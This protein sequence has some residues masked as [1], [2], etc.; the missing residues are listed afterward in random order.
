MTFLCPHCHKPLD[1]AELR[2]M[3]N[4][5]IAGRKRPG[6]KGLVRNPKGRPKVT[7]DYCHGT[8]ML[9]STQCGWCNNGKSGHVNPT[10]L[11]HLPPRG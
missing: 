7:C 2:K 8:G 1:P 6:A 11:K 5:E 10:V 9:G 4:K 3:L